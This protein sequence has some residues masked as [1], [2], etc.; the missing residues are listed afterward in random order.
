MRKT[1]YILK[2]ICD[3]HRDKS[4]TISLVLWL[5]FWTL[6]PNWITIATDDGAL[7]KALIRFTMS[8]L[9]TVSL[10]VISLTLVGIIDYIKELKIVESWKRYSM[11]YDKEYT[12]P[13]A[14]IGD[15]YND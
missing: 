15:K 2:N 8:L 7:V 13:K 9:V 4:I 6:Y 11:E 14:M 3:E 10:Y 1:W 5:S 12:V